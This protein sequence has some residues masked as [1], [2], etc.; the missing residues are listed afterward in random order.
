MKEQYST[1]LKMN[2]DVIRYAKSNTLL[3]GIP[4][5]ANL[6]PKLTSVNDKMVAT[7]KLMDTEDK[8]LSTAVENATEKVVAPLFSVIKGLDIYA[9]KQNNSTL[10]TN[11]YISRSELQRASSKAV[12]AKVKS[13]VKLAREN[14]DGLKEYSITE[15]LLVAIEKSTEVLTAAADALQSCLEEKKKQTTEFEQL[16]DEA[17]TILYDMDSIAEIIS[18]TQ[19]T[20]YKGYTDARNRKESTESLFTITVLSEETGRPE[21]NARVLIQSTTR[22]V[23]DQPYVLL[24]RKTGKTGTVRNGK[25]EFDIY[26]MT[27]EK[28]GCETYTKQFTVADNNQ[29]QLEVMLK[30]IEGLN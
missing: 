10:V 28:I 13:V 27:V 20:A 7:S 3:T 14:I 2:A 5:F 4:A 29:L 23:K 24:D 21:E 9:A 22:K 18:L 25:R 12:E 1:F 16:M 19:P 30:K 15:E 8:G 11:L 6:L 26:K 17:K